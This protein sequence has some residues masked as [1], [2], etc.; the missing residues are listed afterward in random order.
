VLNLGWNA[1]FLEQ[2]IIGNVLD[3]KNLSV[4][5]NKSMLKKTL[6]YSFLVVG[7]FPWNKS[8]EV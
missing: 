1:I 2:G 3:T 6:N 5:P 7:V 4:K 8:L